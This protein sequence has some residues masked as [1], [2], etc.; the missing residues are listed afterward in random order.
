[1][2]YNPNWENQHELRKL[3]DWLKTKPRDE[4]YNYA[5]PC[6]CANAQFYKALGLKVSFVGNSYVLADG[7]EFRLPPGFDLV[8]AGNDMPEEDWTFGA[9]LK[10]CERLLSVGAVL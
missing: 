6:N 9:A 4:R 10:R 5:D 8:A 3:R 1:M 7:R 2:L